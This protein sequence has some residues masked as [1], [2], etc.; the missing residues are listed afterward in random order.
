MKVMKELLLDF[1]TLSLT[2]SWL[3]PTEWSNH[4][5]KNLAAFAARFLLCI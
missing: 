1:T 3:V 4:M 2:L 5:L